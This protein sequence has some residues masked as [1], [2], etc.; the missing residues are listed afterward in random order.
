[1][2]A[3][4]LAPNPELRLMRADDIPVVAALERESYDYPWTEGIFRDCLRVGYHCVVMEG[5]GGALQGYAIMSLVADE[6]HLLNLCIRPEC[7]RCGLGRD[8]LRQVLAV[9]AAAGARRTFLEVRPS[10]AAAL[11]LYASEGF[12]K[13]GRRPRYYRAREGREDAVILACD[14]DDVARRAEVK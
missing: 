8:M 6:A 10:N 11:A 9:A 14:L 4:A 13:I 12:V 5:D 1:M 7:R 2:S 3:R